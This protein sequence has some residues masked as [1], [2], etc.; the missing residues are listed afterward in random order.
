[1]G[2]A[3]VRSA[4]TPAVVAAALALMGTIDLLMLGV[5]V[6]VLPI[7]ALAEVI[8][9]QRVREVTEQTQGRVAAPP[10]GRRS[11]R[12]RTRSCCSSRAECEPSDSIRHC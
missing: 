12:M 8:G 3:L 10:T 11:P 5:V 4:A 7:T 2:D 6:G 1:V 9:R